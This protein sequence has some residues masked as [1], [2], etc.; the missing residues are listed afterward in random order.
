MHV[1]PKRALRSPTPASSRALK[2]SEV[3]FHDSR[4]ASPHS[5]RLIPV[6]TSA[7]PAVVTLI[8]VSGMNSRASPPPLALTMTKSSTVSHRHRADLNIL[9]KTGAASLYGSPFTC[10]DPE[11]E[12][13]GVFAVRETDLWQI[14]NALILTWSHAQAFQEPS[15]HA[16]ASLCGISAPRPPHSRPP[17]NAYGCDQIW[18]KTNC[19]T[20]SHAA[21]SHR[22]C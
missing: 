14:H 19:I 6:I 13:A 8:Y 22:S 18:T 17:V 2:K 16:T 4:I 11:Q 20:S 9:V 10:T 7:N 3:L 21:A 15:P 1:I 12:S 5:T